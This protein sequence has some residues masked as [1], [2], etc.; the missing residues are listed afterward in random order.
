[1]KTSIRVPQSHRWLVQPLHPDTH[2]TRQ[3]ALEVCVV[4]ARGR[5]FIG[6]VSGGVDDAYCATQLRRFGKYPQGPLRSWAEIARDGLNFGAKLA[7]LAGWAKLTSDNS[8][9]NAGTS[10]R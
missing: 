4:P 1:M 5:H 7:R 3:A 8:W 10:V 9:K 6:R 2:R